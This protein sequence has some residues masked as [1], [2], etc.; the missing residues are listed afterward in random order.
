MLP[1]EETNRNKQKALPVCL[2]LTSTFATCPNARITWL[3]STATEFLEKFRFVLARLKPVVT[4]KMCFSVSFI[5][6]H[7]RILPF[8][9]APCGCGFA[10]LR[11]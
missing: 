7:L 11:P 3:S 6:L 8:R 2:E 10:A 1:G 4:G 9:G 5:L